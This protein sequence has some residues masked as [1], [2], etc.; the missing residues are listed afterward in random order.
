MERNVGMKTHANKDRS[1]AI[2][3]HQASFHKQYKTK[4]T[5]TESTA[6]AIWQ[7]SCMIAEIFSGLESIL[8]AQYVTHALSEN[9]PF[10][11]IP[12]IRSYHFSII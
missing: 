3:L 8:H 1:T 2:Q 9:P 10:L 12:Q 4:E 6:Q 5:T 11:H 7:L